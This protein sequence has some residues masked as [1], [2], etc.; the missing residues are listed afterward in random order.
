MNDILNK[1]IKYNIG[2]KVIDNQIQLDV[3]KDVNIAPILEEIKLN[4]EQLILHFKTLKKAVSKGNTPSIQFEKRNFENYVSDGEHKYYELFYQQEKE[5]IRYKIIG[6]FDFNIVFTMDFENIE[7]PIIEKTLATILSRH[8]S[9]RTQYKFINKLPKQYI[10][11]DYELPIAYHDL[12]N[13]SDK[14][15]LLPRLRHEAMYRA[16]DLEKEL[17]SFM[18]LIRNSDERTTLIFTIHHA[19]ADYS[20]IGILKREILTIIEA[21]KHYKDNPLR[22]LK[23]QYRHY[24]QWL[25]STLNSEEGIKIKNE[26][27]N[28]IKASVSGSLYEGL[29]EFLNN[30]NNTYK[31]HLQTELNQFKIENR[32]EIENRA[33]GK[34]VNIIPQKGAIYAV[35]LDDYLIKQIEKAAI[36]YKVSSFILL[37]SS[38]VLASSKFSNKKNARVYIPFST[39]VVEEF[40]PIVGYL[41]NIVVLC[42][43]VS[44]E[45]TLEKF[46]RYVASEFFKFSEYR[47]YPS[48]EILDELDLSLD[49]L[50][51]MFINYI[52]YPNP[53]SSEFIEGHKEDPSCHFNLGM[54]ISE[55]KNVTLMEIRYNL[56]TYSKKDIERFTLLYIDILTRMIENND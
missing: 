35:T 30:H 42:L 16:F 4:K 17:C 9:L 11:E 33:F 39:R 52:K 51:P 43:K 15:I 20:S 6:K 50:A 37:L 19:N 26:Y 2:V 38:F 21:Y 18:T 28:K 34:L 40:E 29:I 44:S 13:V 41:N 47:L 5:Y 3:P 14:D 23:T 8:E 24:G 36:I 46:I 25:N 48:E 10:V 45:Y 32:Q 54:T 49:M 55:Y 53:L 22:D 1:L 7:I 31:R 56:N 27:L 12:K